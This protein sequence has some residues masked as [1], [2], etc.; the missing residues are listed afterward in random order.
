[1][2]LTRGLWGTRSTSHCR[3]WTFLPLVLADKVQTFKPDQAV[4]L[5]SLYES[6]STVGLGAQESGLRLCIVSVLGYALLFHAWS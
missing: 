2:Q 3:T 5:L 1:M 4:C 6:N